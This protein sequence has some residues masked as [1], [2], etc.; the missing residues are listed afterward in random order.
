MFILNPRQFLTF[1]QMPYNLK[2]NEIKLL[3]DI[4][5]GDYF[6]DIVP[7]RPVENGISPEKFRYF[8][9]KKIKRK[10]KKFTLV[11]NKYFYE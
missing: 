3:E 10:V 9:G 1:Q 8:I 7:L 6:E 5:Y 2:E 11:K 4:L